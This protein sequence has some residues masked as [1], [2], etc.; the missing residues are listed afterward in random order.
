MT[1]IPYGN[2]PLFRYTL[3]WIL[4]AN[5]QILKLLAP[6]QLVDLALRHNHILQDFIV[7][8]SKMKEAL[9]LAHKELQVNT[10]TYNIIDLL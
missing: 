1:T 2:H 4:P 7:P 6:R 9:E 8:V 5:F 10:Y 3:G